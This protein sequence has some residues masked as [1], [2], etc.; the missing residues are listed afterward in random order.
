MQCS[1]DTLIILHNAV[2]VN[3]LLAKT[4]HFF[5]II[6]CKVS[7]THIVYLICTIFHTSLYCL[8]CMFVYLLVWLCRSDCL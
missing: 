1:L 4:E 7:K 6:I 2:I 3:M 5:S 8:V